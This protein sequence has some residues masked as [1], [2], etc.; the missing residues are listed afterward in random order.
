MSKKLFHLSFYAILSL[1]VLY[2]SIQAQSIDDGKKL[3]RNESFIK[4]VETFKAIATK[5]NSPEAWYYL[6]ESYFQKGVLDSAKIA[7]QKGIEVK[8]DFGLNYAGLAKVLFNLKDITGGEKNI[9]QALKIA[10]EKDVNLIQAVAEAYINGGK[11]LFS[12]S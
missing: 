9:A 1:L 8:A 7:F 12:E 5:S 11:R 6:G 3:L 4:A 10:D 2:T